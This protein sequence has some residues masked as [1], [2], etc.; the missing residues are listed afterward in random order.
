M[1]S[2]WV[3]LMGLVGGMC[4][5]TRYRGSGEEGGGGELD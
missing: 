3:F 4:V 5:L 1:V 2:F